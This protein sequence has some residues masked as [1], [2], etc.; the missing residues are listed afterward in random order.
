MTNP[1]RNSN[2][3]DLYDY[4]SLVTEIYH[5]ATE[6]DTRSSMRCVVIRELINEFRVRHE[7][8]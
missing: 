6:L 1:H 8:V 7:I 5:A 3:P 4:E 2:P